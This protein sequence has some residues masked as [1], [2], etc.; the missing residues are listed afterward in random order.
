MPKLNLDLKSQ[1]PDLEIIDLDADNKDDNMTLSENKEDYVESVMS[2]SRDRN[3]NSNSGGAAAVR[4]QVKKLDR[5][6]WNFCSDFQSQCNDIIHSIMYGKCIK[7][8]QGRLERVKQISK[9]NEAL[10]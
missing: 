6:F 3:N 4:E 2:T 8:D 10:Q 5:C 9:G 7:L 1:S